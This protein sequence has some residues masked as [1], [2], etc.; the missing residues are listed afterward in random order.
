MK[1]LLRKYIPARYWYTLSNLRN[2]IGGYGHT[3]YS[4]FGEDI[5]LEK[6]FSGKNNGHY[7]DIGAH[8][9]KRYSNTYLLHKRGWSG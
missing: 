3:Y 2:S 8:H 5:V 9:P 4:Q 7:V 1:K 6:I